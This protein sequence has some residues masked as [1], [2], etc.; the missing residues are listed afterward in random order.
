MIAH[1]TGKLI[2]KSPGVSIIDCQGVGYEVFHTPFTAE[3]LLSDIVSLHIH[4]N[5]REDALHLFGFLSLDEKALFVELV[6][7]SGVGPRLA[8]GILSGIPFPELTIAI[9]T[10]D[11]S[12]LTKI[13]GVGKKTAERIVI[14]LADKMQHHEPSHDPITLAPP[15]KT[16]AELESV[17]A[18]LGY[19]GSEIR[20]ALQAV[21]E[22]HDDLENEPLEAWV[23]LAL[24]ELNQHKS[25]H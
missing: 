5:V 12:R 6:K 22:R 13:S 19:Q 2:S 23:K 18:N 7:I 20:R 11:V 17:L 24:G 9:G 10:K 1:L 4:T 25:Y 16:N 14:E 21:R 8:L 15:A 3:K